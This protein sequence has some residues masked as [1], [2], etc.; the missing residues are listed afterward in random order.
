MNRINKLPVLQKIVN[1]KNN[2]KVHSMKNVIN[3]ENPKNQIAKN[4]L[5]LDRLLT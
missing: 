3:K 2:I 4:L 1:K 5:L